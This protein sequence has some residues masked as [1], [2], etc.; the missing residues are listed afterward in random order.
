MAVMTVACVLAALEAPLGSH[1][2]AL[3]VALALI[4]VGSVATVIRRTHHMVN[5]LEAR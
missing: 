3:T 5:E 1:G 4:V 2:R